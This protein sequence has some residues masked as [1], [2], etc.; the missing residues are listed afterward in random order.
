MKPKPLSLKE[1]EKWI[2]NRRKSLKHQFKSKNYELS[3]RAKLVW[4]WLGMVKKEYKKHKQHL[5][6]KCEFWLRYCQKPD[7]L[8]KDYPILYSMWIEYFITRIKD[9]EEERKSYMEWLFK[10]TFKDVLG[11]IK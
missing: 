11:D 8:Q 9:S 2:D 3:A 6:S 1:F 7:L 4:E 10:L 5:K